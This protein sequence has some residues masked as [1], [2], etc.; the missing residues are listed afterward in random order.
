M[1]SLR[2][3]DNQTSDP[4]EVRDNHQR[5]AN[6]DEH[7]CVGNEVGKDHQREAADQGHD[8]SLLP[9]VQEEAEADR[10]E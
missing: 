5:D 4:Q 2:P 10:A 7:H 8:G 9:A 1:A 6:R 3:D